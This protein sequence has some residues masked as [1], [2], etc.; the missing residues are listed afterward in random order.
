MYVKIKLLLRNRPPARQTL[1]KNCMQHLIF[2]LLRSERDSLINRDR[3]VKIS[4]E[5][6]IEYHTVVVFSVLVV[7]A[8]AATRSFEVVA[9]VAATSAGTL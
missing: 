2:P 1:Y 7:R 8:K 5:R 9:I 3:L 6:D 4:L